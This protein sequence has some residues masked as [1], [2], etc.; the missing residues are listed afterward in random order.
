MASE[1]QPGPA[2]HLG[3]A[4]WKLVTIA[5]LFF[6]LY[7]PLYPQLV[8]TWLEDSNNSH[9]LLIPFVSF[10]LVWLLKDKFKTVESS[11]SLLGLALLVLSLIVYFASYVG[12]LALPARI[13]MITTLTAL[14]LF[15]AGVNVLKLVLF[16]ILFLFFMVPVPETLLNLVSFPLQLYVTDISTRLIELCGIPVYAEGNLL[17]FATYSLEV[18]EACSGIR[19]LVS[20]LSIGTLLAYL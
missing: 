20:F 10:Y 8:K 13:T 7:V 18:T 11:N 2:Q 16:P 9:G 14:V 17:F 3:L 6:L 1:A 12:D 4:P 15:N 5:V 19:S